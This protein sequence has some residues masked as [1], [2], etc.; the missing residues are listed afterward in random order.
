M[1]RTGRTLA[2]AAVLSALGALA[3]SSAAAPA[4]SAGPA[5]SPVSLRFH[6]RAQVA[7]PEIR[8]GEIA[9]IVAEPRV[10]ARLET[11]VVAKAAAFGLTRVLDTDLLFL[12]RLKPLTDCG[13]GSACLALDLERRSVRVTTRSALLPPDSLGSLVDAFLA[14]QDR[15]KGETW[16]WELVRTPAEI[17]VPISPHSLEVDF[18]GNRRKGKVELNLAIRSE[19]RILRNLPLT[20]NLRVE[21]PVLV[22]R[23]PIAR[24]EAIDSSNTAL[25]MRETTQMS[26]QAM[27]DPLALRGHQ[28]KATLAEGRVVT[29]LLVEIPPAVRRG[30]EAE[31]V[32]TNGNV[33][34]TAA[35]VCRQDGIPGQV[36]MAKNLANH[37]LIRVRVTGEGRLEPV[38]GG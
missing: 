7:G 18:S 30:Q 23:R 28:A 15:R 24:G 4:E 38:P 10:A 36:I 20:V 37:K 25:E 26:D 31:I 33:S 17:R 9:R 19:N 29:P 22:A 1:A 6:D 32:Y 35:A 11:L 13:A 16:K 8:L 3:A 27:P 14:S 2:A 21:E 34:I 12:R 5:P